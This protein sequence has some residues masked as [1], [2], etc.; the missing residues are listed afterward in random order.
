MPEATNFAFINTVSPIIEAII[1]R[2]CGNVKNAPVTKAFTKYC[3]IFQN[4][5]D[6]H[7]D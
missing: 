2:N 5:I 1:G 6:E 4:F 3:E 7:H